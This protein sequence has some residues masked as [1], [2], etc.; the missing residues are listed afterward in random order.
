MTREA[1]RGTRIRVLVGDPDSDAARVRAEELS[2]AWLPERCR[3]TL[4]YLRK[5]SGICLRAHGTTYYVS[6]FRFDDVILVNTHTYDTWACHAPVIQ[7]HGASSG[8]M[9]DFYRR[10]I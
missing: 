9:F 8:R 6:L 4:D 10:F 3:S 5:V 2:T 1:T 7:L